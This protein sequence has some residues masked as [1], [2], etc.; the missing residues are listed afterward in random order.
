MFFFC[1]VLSSKQTAVKTLKAPH[2][3]SKRTKSR[4]ETISIEL[5]S[6]DVDDFTRVGNSLFLF[7][8]R[9][10]ERRNLTQL[11]QWLFIQQCLFFHCSHWLSSLLV[12][13]SRY[14]A[15]VMII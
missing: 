15:T 11:D 9:R 12:L 6:T 13:R 14:D 8:G 4:D 10:F 5:S 3:T 2:H 1:S 7:P